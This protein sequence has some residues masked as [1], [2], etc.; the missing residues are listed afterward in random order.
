MDSSLLRLRN[1]E[2]NQTGFSFIPEL[3]DLLTG[4]V[5]RQLVV[6]V[7]VVPC[8][9]ALAAVYLLVTPPHFTAKL[10]LVIDNYSVRPLSQGQ[11]ANS[12][13]IDSS[14]VDTQVEILRSEAIALAVVNQLRLADMPEFVEPGGIGGKLRG[15]FQSKEATE[16]ERIR[17]AMQRVMENRIVS[18]VG[19]TYLIEIGFTSLSRDIAA[20]VA[21]AIAEAYIVNQ[22][23]TKYQATKRA[24][25]WVQDQL[26]ELQA[27]SLAA[28]RAVV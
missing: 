8:C 1:T 21:N 3:F 2:Q 11:A 13:T 5:Q 6:F 26:A 7:I 15:L 4:F 14:Q 22:L 9:L 27:Q 10:S 17:S 16:P 23:D 12:R 24:S 20:D 18:R 19:R 25:V 28:D